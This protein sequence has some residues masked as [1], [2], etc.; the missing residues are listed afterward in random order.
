MNIADYKSTY[1]RLRD[2]VENKVC[3]FLNQH[4]LGE[5]FEQIKEVA[6]SQ[7]QNH[8]IGLDQDLKYLDGLTNGAVERVANATNRTFDDVKQEFEKHYLSSR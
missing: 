5:E 3:D 7:S 8:P 4:N 6:Q 2:Y 1:N